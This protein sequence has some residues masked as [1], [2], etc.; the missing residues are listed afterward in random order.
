MS[1]I[2]IGW[3]TNLKVPVTQG[4]QAKATANRLYDLTQV[5]RTFIFKKGIL[6]S[7]GLVDKPLRSLVSVEDDWNFYS[8]KIIR[9]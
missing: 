4:I 7:L 6:L 5:R 8:L 3:K 1:L 2:L 9:K